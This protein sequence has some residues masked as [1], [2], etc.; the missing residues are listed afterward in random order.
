MYSRGFRSI[1]LSL[2]ICL[3]MR[4]L[5]Q[6]LLELDHHP[7]SHRLIRQLLVGLP[8]VRVGFLVQSL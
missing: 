2:R 8:K 7:I 6:S 4:L 3:H 5:I 1:L